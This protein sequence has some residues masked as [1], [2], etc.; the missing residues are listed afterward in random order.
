M[1][2]HVMAYNAFQSAIRGGHVWLQLNVGNHKTL[3]HGEE[4]DVLLL[5]NKSGVNLHLPQMKSGGMVFYNSSSITE[6]LSVVRDDLIYCPVPFKEIITENVPL[7]MVNVILMGALMN[8]LGLDTK[9]A[10]E[11]IVENFEKR[12]KGQDIIDLNK[13]IFNAGIDYAKAN[14]KALDKIDGDGKQRLFMTGNEALGLGLLAHGIKFYAAYPMSP[15][16]GVLHY[17]ATKAKTDNIVVKQVEDEIAAINWVIGATHAGVR[18]ATA[19]AGGGFALMIEALGLAGMLEEPIVVIDVMRGGPSTGIPTKQEMPDIPLVMGGSGDFARIV[20]APKD[21][22][23]AFHQAGRA[24]N[25]AEKYQTPVILMSDTFLSEHFQTVDADDFDFD[26][27]AINRGNLIREHNEP[28]LYKRFAHGDNGVPPTRLV[29]GAKGGMYT[30]ASDEH[31]ERGIVI[32]DVL[33]G[34]PESLEIRNRI[35]PRRMKKLDTMRAEDMRGPEM[36][37]DKK[38]D[39]TLM[40]WGSTSDMISEAVEILSAEGYSVNQMHFV[41]IFPLPKEKV[42]E[43]L[44]SC[45]EIIA[46][47]NNISNQFPRHLLAET[48]FEVTKSINRYDGEP[49]TGHFIAEEI[50]K[51]DVLKKKELANV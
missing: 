22:E 45:K 27:E 34:L 37:G 43:T 48:G 31:D 24:F 40:G 4:P 12:N 42:L 28:G 25:L 1:G 14:F 50:K 29:P 49:F 2:L 9:V 13:K 30:A 46:V 3:S 11:F 5:L 21:T 33:A 18:A 23:D 41:D 8:A 38:A 17:L 19:T 6:D 39:I 16:T 15:S 36:T 35:H 20:I 44:K 32:S 7:V 10:E 51:L 47:E 26:R